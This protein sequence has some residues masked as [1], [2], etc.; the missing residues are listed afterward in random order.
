MKLRRA[1]PE[2]LPYILRLEKHYNEL[3]FIGADSLETHQ[4]R[5]ADPDCLYW[6]VESNGQPAGYAVLRGLASPNRSVELKR[7]AIAEPGQGLGR[8]VLAAIIAEAFEN[9]SAH[10]LWLDVFDHNLR[11]QHVYRSL[12]FV[13]EGV[14][15]ECVHYNGIYRSLVLMSIL[16]FEYRARR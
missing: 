16:E 3:G 12:G 11:A 8:R 15:R 10:R 2:D 5:F 7:I 9:L 1:V 14:L 13:Q 6:V 4:R